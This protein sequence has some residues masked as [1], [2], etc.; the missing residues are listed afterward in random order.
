VTF[1]GRTDALVGENS[2]TMNVGERGRIY[3]VN[4]GLNLDSNFHPIGAQWDL[5]YPEAA[6]HQ[7]N[8]AIRGSQSTLVVA[9]GGTVVEID[10]LV[11]STIILVD[12]AL[13]RTFYKGAIGTI[14]I[15]GDANPELFS[16]GSSEAPPEESGSGG[17]ASAANGET[18]FNATCQACHG[19][20][21]QGVD[22]LGPP[23]ASNAF[24]AGLSDVE[25]VQFINEG[26]PVDHPDNTTGIAMPPKGG[27]PALSDADLADIVAYLRTLQ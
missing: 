24:I 3:F 19:A 26:R 14:V 5:V 20:A 13:V 16:G 21:G 4:E 10:A 15:S 25:L 27:N 7:A 17:E 9:G 22:G 2:L 6:T 18:I 1:N 23:L 12:H 8:R 11:P